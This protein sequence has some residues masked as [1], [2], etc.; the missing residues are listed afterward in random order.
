M[1][2]RFSRSWTVFEMNVDDLEE[3]QA[4]FNFGHDLVHQARA[5]ATAQSVLTRSPDGPKPGVLL[6]IA[7]NQVS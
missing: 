1:D 2:G 3:S 5:R 7:A 4:R 6:L